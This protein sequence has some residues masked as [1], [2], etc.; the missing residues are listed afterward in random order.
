MGKIVLDTS[1]KPQDQLNK[2]MVVKEML[3]KQLRVTITDG[4]ILEGT[5]QCFDNSMNI[6]LQHC[7]QINGEGGSGFFSLC[8]QRFLCALGKNCILPQV[9]V[10]LEWC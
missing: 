6:I 9:I 8:S 1:N 4:R 3:E 7:Y 5:F 2:E 10:A